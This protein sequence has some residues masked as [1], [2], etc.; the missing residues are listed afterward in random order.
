MDEN[1]QEMKNTTTP[2]QGTDSAPDKEEN[3]DKTFTQAQL[4]AI[5][6]DRLS[7]AKKDMPAEDE[8]QDFRTWKEQ[9]QSES[10]KATA[11]IDK[12]NRERDETNAKY[13]T[14]EK[15][16]AVLA[17][18]IPADKADAYARLAEGYTSEGTPF[19]KAI[20]AALADFP[21]VS[22]GVPGTGCNPPQ[23]EPQRK[24]RPSGTVI[25]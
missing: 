12:A 4:D 24:S 21:I 22:P 8:L 23:S 16:L 13:A 3:Q 7:R 6:A 15:K 11:A 2:G 9:Q 18:G 17:K 5:I 1:R 14:L 25:L 20:D 19:D 10:E